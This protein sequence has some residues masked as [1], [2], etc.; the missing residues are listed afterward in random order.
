MELDVGRRSLN[1]DRAAF[2][3]LRGADLAAPVPSCPEWNLGGL[4]AHVGVVHRFARRSMNEPVDGGFPKATGPGNTPLAGEDVWDWLD[5]G[6][7]DLIDDFASRDLEQTCW[8]WA[9]PATG[10]WWLRRQVHET[11]IHRWDAEQA[12]GVESVVNGDRAADGIDE[13][14]A[15]Q[16]GR[17]WLP[18]D[19]L[20][21]TIHL[22]ATDGDGEWLLNLGDGLTWTTGHHKGD[23]AIRGG[24][25]DLELLLWNRMTLDRFDTFGDDDLAARFLAA[26]SA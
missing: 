5:T 8:S 10:R 19:S 15:L 3:A 11:A 14:L 25:A 7:G 17:G 16:V 22:H 21:G 18:P 12:V 23:V 26:L 13:W 6:L 1:H 4:L 20:R 24:R 9:G 2:V